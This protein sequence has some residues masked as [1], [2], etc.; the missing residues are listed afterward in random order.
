M[1]T[2]E[3]LINAGEANEY[4][5]FFD[6]Q[7]LHTAEIVAKERTKRGHKIQH[8]ATHPVSKLQELQEVNHTN[9]LTTQP[10]AFM[11]ECKHNPKHVWMTNSSASH[12]FQ[13]RCSEC[14]PAKKVD[15]ITYMLAVDYDHVSAAARSENH[16]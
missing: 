12:V 11:F 15:P 9:K 10:F 8:V 3:F 14:K 7:N 13:E 1:K 6:S 5:L 4:T 16:A 2:F